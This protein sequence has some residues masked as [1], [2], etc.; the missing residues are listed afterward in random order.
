MPIVGQS[1]PIAQRDR[2]IGDINRTLN[3]A[4]YVTS[5][6]PDATL[7]SHADRPFTLVP[8]AQRTVDAWVAERRQRLVWANEYNCWNRAAEGAHSLLA[9]TGVGLSPTDDAFTAGI[10][11]YLQADSVDADFHAAVAFK[12]QGKP[13]T[14]ALDLLDPRTGPVP[15][16]E[17]S[18]G[19][20]VVVRRPW[21]GSGVGTRATFVNDE[22]FAF[23]RD[24][25]THSWLNAP[26]HGVRLI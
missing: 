25:L 24:Q 7:R 26:K 9:R 14:W 4:A 17:W 15:L 21:S 8:V 12:I 11:H 19:A 6:F 23:A 3:H 13:G 18:F 1:V 22:G 5:V 2:A 20:P 10:A 16:E